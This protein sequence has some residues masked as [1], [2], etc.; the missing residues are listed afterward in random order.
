MRG[1]HIAR[2]DPAR[3]RWRGVPAKPYKGEAAGPLRWKGVER[4]VLVGASGEPTAFHLRYFEIAPGGFSS[5]E[6]H[7]H[8]H[9]VLVVRGHGRVRLGEI[10]RRVGPMDFVY[11]PPRMPHQFRAGR[12][13]F[14]FLCPV[15]AVRD[16][17]RPARSD[18][19]ARRPRGRYN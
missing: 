3:F 18:Q 17:P 2:F 19:L 6:R 7:R 16:R 12:E 15:D 5:F 9:A 13:P 10:E 8:A 1:P 4:F 14:G 11:I